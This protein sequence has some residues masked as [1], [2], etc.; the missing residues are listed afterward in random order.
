[1]A[2]MS[3]A[4][5][6]AVARVLDFWFAQGKVELWFKPSAAFDK[7][8]REALADDYER[9]AAGA[10][11]SWRETAEGCLAL[12]L[13]LDQVPRNLF[14]DDARA[15]A[16]DARALT[17]ARHAIAEGFDREIASQS[18]R[19]FLYLPLEH[20]ETIA[21]QEEGCRLMRTLDENPEW[22]EWA[23][24]HREVIARFGRFPHRN[25]ALGRD[26]SEAEEA[27]LKQPGSSF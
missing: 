18:R 9:A 17:I 13:L 1:M 2:D 10:Y 22:L 12:T 15:Y 24:K 16:T 8:V 11:D 6:K 21:D 27:F 25:A 5:R 3:D 20:S 19:R 26:S 23:V 4:N 7:A 14:R